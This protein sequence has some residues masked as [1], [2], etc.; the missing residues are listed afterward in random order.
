LA[1]GATLAGVAGAFSP[2]GCVA[3]P[4]AGGG[5][6]LSEVLCESGTVLAPETAVGLAPP[7]CRAGGSTFAPLTFGMISPE[8]SGVGGRPGVSLPDGGELAG[9]IAATG[10][11]TTGGVVGVLGDVPATVGTAAAGVAG[12]AGSAGVAGVA[13]VAGVAVATGV[14]GEAGVA[15]SAAVADVAGT[16]G[17][18]GI[19]GV[20]ATTELL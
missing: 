12:V 15:G 9:V 6:V 14:P 13:C 17:I 19:A 1:G 18:A 4:S 20:V 11:A 2:F 10:V 7:L 3:L 5:A 8:A 16:A